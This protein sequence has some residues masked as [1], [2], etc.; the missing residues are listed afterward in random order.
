MRVFYTISGIIGDGREPSLLSC[1]RGTFLCLRA[2]ARHSMKSIVAL[3]ALSTT[4]HPP[5]RARQR[6]STAWP[7][8]TARPPPSRARG[9][10]CCARRS[11]SREEG[12]RG[13]TRAGPLSLSFSSTFCLPSRACRA[14]K[15]ARHGAGHAPRARPRLG[16]RDGCQSASLRAGPCG[17]HPFPAHRASL[18]RLSVEGHMRGDEAKMGGRAVAAWGAGNV[19]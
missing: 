9:G 7:P 18:C 3:N 19:C 5:P 17:E 15:G 14:L 16:R 6:L 8:P 2:H 4:A 11:R 13:R 10:C 1:T 12:G